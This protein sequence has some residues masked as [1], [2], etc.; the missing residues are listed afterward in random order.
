MEYPGWD[1]VKD[2][3]LSLDDDRMAGIGAA[4]IADDDVGVGGV[5]I[6]HL[7]LSL[8]A[9]LRADNHRTAH[10]RSP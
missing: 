9:P 4:L 10:N 7:R 6:D 1:E 2:M 3:F 5:V 8:I